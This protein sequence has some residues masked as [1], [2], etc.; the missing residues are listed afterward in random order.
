MCP[1]VGT[2]S[3]R[4]M[5]AC[6]LWVQHLPQVCLGQDWLL[7][8]GGRPVPVQQGSLPR[9]A[10]SGPQGPAGSQPV[11]VQAS[12]PWACSGSLAVQALFRCSSG[13]NMAIFAPHT[14]YPPSQCGKVQPCGCR[15][16]QRRARVAALVAASMVATCSCMGSMKGAGAAH[17]R[18]NPFS[19]VWP[20][21][22]SAQ[23]TTL[24]SPCSWGLLAQPCTHPPKQW[25]CSGCGN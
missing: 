18:F 14:G 23:T 21:L 7:G 5:F 4:C 22:V 24:S 11:P 3:G 15:C 8:P 10:C 19:F 6:P 2:S 25:C 9:L 12:R 1:W 13:R 17:V 16:K 20:H